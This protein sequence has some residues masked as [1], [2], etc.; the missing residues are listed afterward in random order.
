[1]TILTDLTVIDA[2]SGLAGS[3]ATLLLAQ[4][5][6][7]VV[8]V[9]P[10]GGDPLRSTPGFATWNRNKSSIV[11]D[12]QADR[13]RLQSLLATADV[14]VHGL[15]PARAAHLE[16]DDGTLGERYPALVVA[17]VTG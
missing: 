9:E 12:L 15:T 1:M 8:K 5:G 13:D 3:V 14:F 17:A 2:T 6:A 7:L 4:A 10:P 11:L 16:L